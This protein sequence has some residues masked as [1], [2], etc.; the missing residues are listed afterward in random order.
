M[1]LA[2]EEFMRRVLLHVLPRGFHR[3]R[4]Y[5]LLGNARRARELATARTLLHAE[6]PAPQENHSGANADGHSGA[7]R[8]FLCRHCGAPMIIV[9][10]L[11]PQPHIRA[12]P[13]PCST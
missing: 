6:P 9:C 10:A 2:A 13:A 5:G 8:V 7:S 3:I 11:P 1:T 12:P 4:H